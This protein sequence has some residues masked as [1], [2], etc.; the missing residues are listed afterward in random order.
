MNI[1][2]SNLTMKETIDV[3]DENI[4]QQKH[5]HHVVIN[6]GK[7][8]SMQKDTEL[9][10]NVT[11]SDILDADGQAIVWACRFLGLD[12][13]ERVTGIDLM[14]HLLGLAFRKKYKCYF[15]GAKEKIVKQVVD[16]V[17][18]EYS[19]EIIAGYRNGYY[20]SEEEYSIAEEIAKSGAQILFVAITSPKKENFLANYKEAL[21]KINF[22]MGVGG[23][24]DVL[25]GFTKRAPKWMQ[26][27]GLEWFFRLAQEPK[28]MWK[29]YLI[30]NFTFILLVLKYKVRMFT[31]ANKLL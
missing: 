5:L 12:I 27:T 7:V 9:L 22:I 4:R 6:A 24:F 10:E 20:D 28:R 3:I 8:V 17:S 15:F 16:K 19:P 18:K 11:A 26:K 21:S 1:P 13:S 31:S 30:G 14:I 23:S 25:A 29:R 2:V